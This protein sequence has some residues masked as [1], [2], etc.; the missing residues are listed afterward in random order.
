MADISLFPLADQLVF[1]DETEFVC[2][3]QYVARM[4]IS[5]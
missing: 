2:D 1:V 3:T 5:L 4:Q